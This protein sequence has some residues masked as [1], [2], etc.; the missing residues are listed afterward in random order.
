[1]QLSS[2]KRRDVRKKTDGCCAYCGR[3]LEKHEVTI[4]H[5]IP[6]GRGGARKDVS[7]LVFACYECNQAKGNKTALE[8][9]R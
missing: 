4:D 3:P 5:V 8:F 6:L 2:K 7:N 1:M 9:M